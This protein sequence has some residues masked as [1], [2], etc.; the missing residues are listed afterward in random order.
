MVRVQQLAHRVNNSADFPFLLATAVARVQLPVH[1]KTNTVFENTGN[2][3]TVG[4]D[5]LNNAQNKHPLSTQDRH[6]QNSHLNN[7]YGLQ[8]KL[9]LVRFSFIVEV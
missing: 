2:T 3:L 5:V 9:T 1:A 8:S 6:Y 7:Q 4:H